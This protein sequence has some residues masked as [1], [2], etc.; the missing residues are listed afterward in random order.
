MTSRSRLSRKVL[1]ALAVG[2]LLASLV[3]LFLFIQTYRTQLRI[4]RGFASDQV[5]RLFQVSLENAMLKR[6]LPGLQEIITRL[7]QQP[8]IVS[9]RI[10]RSSARP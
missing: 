3:F 5:N 2:L 10:I 4:E 6:D 7:G 9:V 8:G 1:S